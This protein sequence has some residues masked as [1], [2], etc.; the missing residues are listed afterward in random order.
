MSSPSTGAGAGLSDEALEPPLVSSELAFKGRVWDIRRDVFD[1]GDHQLT[2]DYVDHPGAVAVLAIDDQDRVLLIQQ[3]RH[4]VRLREWELPA[5]LRDIADED[6]LI[7]AQR[8]L[9]EEVDLAA[10]EWSE[11]L[12]FNTS[13]GGSNESIIIYLARGLVATETPFDRHEEEADIVVRWVPLED[14]VTGVLEG[15]LRNSILAIAVLAAHA[16]A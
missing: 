9:G 1:Y 15:D 2:R 16:R 12:T 4:P 8:E 11:L 6:P 14:A 13:P 3:Y 5:G 10:S 7:A